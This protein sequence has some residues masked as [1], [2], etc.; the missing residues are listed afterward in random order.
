ME[1]KYP[2]KEIKVMDGVYIWKPEKKSN[3]NTNNDTNNNINNNS[4]NNTNKNL[5]KKDV[6]NNYYLGTKSSIG[7]NEYLCHGKDELIRIYEI[8][9]EELGNNVLSL[10]QSNEDM[11]EF[12]PNDY[13]L[14][15]AR[16]ENLELI[17]KKL[18]EI[19]KI[20][21]KMKE[22]CEIHPLVS[23]DIFEYFGIGKSSKDNEVNKNEIENK[24]DLIE[25]NGEENKKINNNINN[26]NNNENNKEDNSINNISENKIQNDNNII[27]ELEL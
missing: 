9:F 5:E 6:N 23:V 12:D 20:Q 7:E 21:Q 17:D 24:K 11:M 26:I 13:D 25:V 14:I 1:E 27:T 10:F 4:T 2:I 22:I 18:A 3:N 16:E 8:E 15:Q 19:V